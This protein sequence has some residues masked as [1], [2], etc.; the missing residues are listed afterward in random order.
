LPHLRYCHHGSPCKPL[1]C[2]SDQRKNPGAKRHRRNARLRYPYS[3]LLHPLRYGA[4]KSR[5]LRRESSKSVH[6]AGMKGLS[7][8]VSPTLG[9]RE[10]LSDEYTLSKWFTGCTEAEVTSSLYRNHHIIIIETRVSIN[11]VGHICFLYTG[12]RLKNPRWGIFLYAS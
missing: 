9:S 2:L 8:L 10:F 7:R 4:G 3:V 11:I 12:F 5:A 1:V 6:G